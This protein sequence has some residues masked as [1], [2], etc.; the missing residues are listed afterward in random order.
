MQTT[1]NTYACFVRLQVLFCYVNT[2]LQHIL[3]RGFAKN[4][5]LTVVSYP[6]NVLRDK[7][8]RLTR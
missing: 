7:Q 1:K 5:G 2:C 3:L 8:E 6:L 4:P